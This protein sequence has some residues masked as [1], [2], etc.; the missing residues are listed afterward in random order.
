MDTLSLSPS[1]SSILS[2]PQSYSMYSSVNSST[3]SQNPYIKK[4]NKKKRKYDDSLQNNHN[5][6][7]ENR[8]KR[9]KIENKKSQKKTNHKRSKSHSRSQSQSETQSQ[10]QSQC[11]SN[12]NTKKKRKSIQSNKSV[13]LSFP[14][15][16]PQYEILNIN[17]NISQMQ[18][19]YQPSQNQTY[20]NITTNGN[21]NKPPKTHKKKYN[22]NNNTISMTDDNSRFNETAMELDNDENISISSNNS[23][24]IRIKL[25]QFNERSKKFN[26]SKQ[27]LDQ[28]EA[29]V[30]TET[31]KNTNIQLIMQAAHTLFK[32]S[33][34]VI[35]KIIKSVTCISMP[36]VSLLTLS[37][38]FCFVSQLCDLSLSL[39]VCLSV[40]LEINTICHTKVSSSQ[41]PDTFVHFPFFAQNTKEKAK[42][43]QTTESKSP[44]LIFCFKNN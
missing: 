23:N 25:Q 19:E 1:T 20:D 16:T 17:K 38:P 43:K 40:K 6:M 3:R 33:T 27:K 11:Q 5:Y 28:I 39:S 41:V 37:L 36:C 14:P 13:T 21:K 18:I 4:N 10:S 34:S 8:K 30:A 22:N 31:W 12:K 2:S 9:Q 15:L 42:T 32:L 7:N 29:F 24:S 44:T 35:Y 26:I